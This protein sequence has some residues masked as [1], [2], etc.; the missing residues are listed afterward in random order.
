MLL[1]RLYDPKLAQA[2]YLIGC[3][4]SGESLVID[5]H[6]DVEQYLEAAAARGL[7]VTHVTETH[8]HADFVSG[9][10]ELAARTGAAL[11]L[12]GEGG[13]DWTYAF[14]GE[15]AATLIGEGDAFEVGSVRIE[16]MH[17]PG[18]TPEHLVF[19]VTDTAAATAP[20]AA[21]TGDF[22]FVGDVG[23]PDLLEK[24]A[25]VEDSMDAAARTL[26]HSL[27]RFKAQ[28]DYLQ[29]WPGHGAGSACGKGLSSVPHSTVGYERLFNWAF[30]VTDEEEFVR[31]VLEGQPEPPRYFGEMKRI[32]RCGP[33]V[34]GGLP[35]PEPVAASALPEVLTRGATVI[36]TRTASAYAAG[37][38]PGT[39][40]L[41]LN[42][43]FTGWAGWLVPYAGE[44]YLLMDEDRG[45]GL[46]EAVRDLAM[47]GLDRVAGY[48]GA[49][50]IE[51]WSNGRR[52]GT[53]SQITAPELAGQLGEGAAR[54][55]DVRA[56][57]EWDTG[58][59]PGAAHIPLGELSEHLARLP[60]DR[61]LVVHCQGGSRSAIAASLLEA[62]GF[63]NVLNLQ[64][65]L[66]EWVAAG[67]PL[68]RPAGG[69]RPD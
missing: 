62:R 11:Y 48:F 67:F 64:G 35:H 59:L 10:R 14:A 5:P 69:T 60:R 4:E 63:G 68:Q 55:I 21:V 43:S 53:I 23:R 29:I 57:S 16:A 58:H 32:N 41:P 3:G 37:H 17:T 46:R 52:P 18:H 27:Q 66:A 2:S 47:I 42:H 65:G 40:N 19:L 28:P 15:A 20:I 38:V 50:A 56:R 22:V 34:L 45:R 13:P 30:A 8:I 33:R 49:D 25:E 51:A 54:V 36:D 31:L 39:L 61:P 1:Q 12:S 6:R 44:L 7:R 9:S 26:F 24:V